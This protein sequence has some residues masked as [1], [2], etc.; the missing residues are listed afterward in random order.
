M[1]EEAQ[2]RIEAHMSWARGIPWS[3]WRDR[4]QSFTRLDGRARN[5]DD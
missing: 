5:T 3:G 2:A 1:L 4:E